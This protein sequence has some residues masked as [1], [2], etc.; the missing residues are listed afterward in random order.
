MV[1]VNGCSWLWR[2]LNGLISHFK[3]HFPLIDW[4]LPKRCKF[5]LKWICIVIYTRIRRFY[6]NRL[7][8]HSKFQQCL[9]RERF[10]MNPLSERIIFERSPKPLN[11]HHS[12]TNGI[13]VRFVT[14]HF[15]G[16]TCWRVTPLYWTSRFES[17]ENRSSNEWFCSWTTGMNCKSC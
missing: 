3:G 2:S 11:T 10:W 13:L 16:W 8:V 15:I 7:T 17:D 1:C 5:S 14:R 6:P 9:I 4:P 12:L